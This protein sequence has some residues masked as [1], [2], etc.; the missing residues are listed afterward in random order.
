MQFKVFVP[1]AALLSLQLS[2]VLAAPVAE[3]E[4]V[5]AS[6]ELEKRIG[7]DAGDGTKAKP[8][9]FNIDCAGVEEVCEAQCAA[10]LCFKSPS[11]LQ[12]GGPG[13]N[14]AQRTASGAGS[15]PFRPPLA[16]LVGGSKIDLSALK[17]ST[18]T[19][20]EDTT[21]ASAKEGGIGCLIAPVDPGHNTKEGSRVSG[22]IS[23]YKAKKD[24]Y[25]KKKY[26]NAGKYCKALD[27]G[28]A[29]DTV[30]KNAPSTDPVNFMYRRTSKKSGNS[31]LWQH[32]KYGTDTWAV[33]FPG[34]S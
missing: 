34:Y 30:C 21:N 10:I 14:T 3:A 25:F 18:W 15:D 8:Y 17:Q 26:H 31:V 5:D 1:V 11:L 32:L 19:S 20:P 33:N 6:F 27:A 9:I 28:K 7:T 29:A 23:H 22:Q 24:E 2:S 16:T 4:S 13:S 12:Y